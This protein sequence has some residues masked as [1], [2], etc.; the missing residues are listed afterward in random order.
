MNKSS[1]LLNDE[2]VIDRASGWHF[3]RACANVRKKM[4][5][6]RGLREAM[7]VNYVHTRKYDGDDTRVLIYVCK[8]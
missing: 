4:K 3:M 8:Y 5:Q 2:C 6:G 7:R 1:S